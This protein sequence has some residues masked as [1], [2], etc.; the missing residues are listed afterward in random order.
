[1]PDRPK[2]RLLV[3]D[4]DDTI[5][6]WFDPWH[7]SFRALLDSLIASTGLSED[8]LVAAIRPVHQRR[9][10]S[11]YSWLLDELE[12]LRPFVAEGSTVAAHFDDALHAQNSAR[13]HHTTLIDGV[14][15]TLTTL[16]GQGTAVAAYTES[17]AFWTRWRFKRTGIDGLITELYSSPDHDM[18][19]GVDLAERRTLS[20]D[21]YHLTETQHHHVPWGVRKPNRQ[22]L[23]QIIR[24]HGVLPEE[25]VYVGDNLD[26]DIAMA[27]DVGAVDVWA[28]YGVSHSD[29]RYGLLQR[30]SHWPDSVIEREVDKRPQAHPK[31]TYVLQERFD[32]I[33]DYVDFLPT[34]RA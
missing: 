12:A 6:R 30:V 19:A 9:G 8:D 25:T 1:M 22:I 32:E 20:E 23:D 11:E 24:E 3:V 7:A 34:G 26:K 28:K 10:T 5:W 14:T 29:A 17:L 16:R 4:L 21:S 13:K 15:E 33:F 31:P 18:P 2:A 27:Q